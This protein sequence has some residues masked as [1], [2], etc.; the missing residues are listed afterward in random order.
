MSSSVVPKHQYSRCIFCE[1]TD[2]PQHKEDVL[3]RWLARELAA[4]GNTET[5]FT[6][7]T[8]YLGES[9]WPT[10]EY[11]AT[12]KLGWE[13]KG[14][15]KRC[16]NGW[17]SALENEAQPLLVPLIRGESCSLSSDQLTVVARWTTK[18]AIMWEYMK[19]EADRRFFTRAERVAMF[20]SRVIPDYTYIYAARYV[21]GKPVYAIGGPMTVSFPG[22]AATSRAY[23]ATL[24]IG[25]LVL[26]LVGFKRPAG[27]VSQKLNIRIPARG[28]PFHKPVWPQPPGWS[29]PLAFVLRDDAELKKF[30]TRVPERIGPAHD[31]A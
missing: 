5:A 27:H 16:N 18:T 2:S 25:Q 13:T 9:E 24:A 12:G 1:Q 14:P 23:C 31:G 26:Q 10:R 21:G 29:W 8:G 11:G 3:P 6:A 22:T 15:C 7:L 17:M 30:A 4:I 19:Y 28:D 20:T